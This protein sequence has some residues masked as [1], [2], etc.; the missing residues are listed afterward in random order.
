MVDIGVISSENS[1]MVVDENLF[2]CVVLVEIVLR[3]DVLKIC[4]LSKGK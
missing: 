4:R 2:Y 1:R 3:L